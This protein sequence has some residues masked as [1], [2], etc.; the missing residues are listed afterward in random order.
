MIVETR[1][2]TR[3][4]SIKKQEVKDKIEAHSDQA[5]VDMV[6]EQEGQE[7]IIAEVE[8]ITQEDLIKKA[9]EMLRQERDQEIQDLE[10]QLKK[11]KNTVQELL[12]ERERQPRLLQ[13]P[14]PLILDTQEQAK[15]V[16]DAQDM[17]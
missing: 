4:A 9:V 16:L 17:T 15:N 1:F 3:S 5:V 11:Y 2:D 8:T 13:E 12:Q 14:E 6:S 10:Q 7:T